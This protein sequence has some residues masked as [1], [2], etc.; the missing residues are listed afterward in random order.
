MDAGGS[1]RV[2][3][4]VAI[5]DRIQVMSPPPDMV[6]GSRLMDGATFEQK[7]S[8]RL[9]TKIAGTIG[10]W[11]T[12]INKSDGF[13]DYTSGLRVYSRKA[14]RALLDLGVRER[15]HAFNWMSAVRLSQ[16]G[17]RIEWVPI[18]YVASGSSA[19]FGSLVEAGK[20]AI[21]ALLY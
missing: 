11:A 8:R 21:T 15:G 20:A 12:A 9:L 1:H 2:D 19:S 6:I 4:M 7:Y 3:D 10:W 5:L 16:E 17:F 13:G 18:V 14:A